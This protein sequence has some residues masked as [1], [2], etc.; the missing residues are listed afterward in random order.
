MVVTMEQV[1]SV[2]YPNEPDYEEASK[3]GPEALPF[4]E[5]VVKGDNPQLAAKATSL[6]SFI[7][8]SGSVR[9]LMSAAQSKYDV[10]RVLA[11][12]SSRNLRVAGIDSVLAILINDNDTSIREHATRSLNI[13]RQRD[14]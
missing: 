11:A 6:A 13:I 9:V 8:D 14:G 10:V 1:L 2:L 3:L 12:V 4:L 7:Q 5:Q